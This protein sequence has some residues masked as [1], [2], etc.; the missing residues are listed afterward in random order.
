[1]KIARIG[2][3]EMV[4]FFPKPSRRMTS[5]DID[6]RAWRVVADGDMNIQIGNVDMDA[7]RLNNNSRSDMRYVDTHLGLYKEQ[8]CTH[9]TK[10]ND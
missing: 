3:F 5:S 9:I 6:F 1:M 4:T 7:K 2:K 10:I 8:Y